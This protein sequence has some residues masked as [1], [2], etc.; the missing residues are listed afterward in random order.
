VNDQWEVPPVGGDLLLRIRSVMPRLPKT[1]LKVAQ[2][3]L[4]DSAIVT[5]CSIAEMAALCGTSQAS[6]T[7]FCQALGLSGYPELKLR[8]AA[9]VGRSP[10]L[11]W[12]LDL[13]AEISAEDPP[14]KLASVLANANVRAIQQT[15]EMLDGHALVDAASAVSSARRIVV[16]GVGGSGLIAQDLQLRLSRIDLPVW[17]PAD[18][19]SALMTVSLLTP[20]DVFLGI[21]RSGRTVEVVEAMNEAHSRGATTIA[22]TSFPSSPL[23]D[24]ASIVLTTHVQ[25]TS[26]RHGSLAA[27]YAQLLVVDCVY[28]AVAQQTYERST[29][30]L[31]LTTRVLASHRSSRRS[32]RTKKSDDE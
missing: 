25:D 2:Q 1:A 6:V 28:T 19:H 31:T 10:Q 7:R 18:S 9:E 29:E 22:L 20:D 21:S 5:T 12:E 13:G 3:V 26:V 27:R 11:T 14:E 24:R 4:D 15:L 8:L 17:A 32:S 23:G 30:A 16:F